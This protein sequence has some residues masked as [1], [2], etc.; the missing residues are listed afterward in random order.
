MVDKELNTKLSIF[1]NFGTL[2]GY[3]LGLL[4]ENNLLIL[5]LPTLSCGLMIYSSTLVCL[6]ALFSNGENHTQDKFRYGAIF[7]SLLVTVVYHPF[8][9]L[10]RV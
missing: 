4:V 7:T 2:I 5:I 9:Y 6:P 3:F 8:C 10:L 1:I